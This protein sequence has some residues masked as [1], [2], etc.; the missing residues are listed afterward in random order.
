MGRVTVRAAV[1]GVA[2]GDARD[3]KQRPDHDESG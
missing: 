3:R 2:C 1:G